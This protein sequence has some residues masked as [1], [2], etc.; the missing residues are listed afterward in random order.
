MD[1]PPLLAR[2][3]CR[4]TRLATV[5]GLTLGLLVGAV[6]VVTGYSAYFQISPSDCTDIGGV[7][8]QNDD[9]TYT[10]FDP[11]GPYDGDPVTYS[12]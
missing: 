10:C 6:E 4:S 7:V 11:G 1:I 3:M 12:A 2:V 8:R 9:D 5:T